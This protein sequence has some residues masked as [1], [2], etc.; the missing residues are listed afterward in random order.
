MPNC[1]L[2]PRILHTNGPPESPPQELLAPFSR[3]LTIKDS[4]RSKF[5]YGESSWTPLYSFW[6]W[7]WLLL[8]TISGTYIVL[9]NFCAIF[10]ST[11]KA[12]NFTEVDI[13]RYILDILFVLFFSPQLNRFYLCPIWSQSFCCGFKFVTNLELK[14]F[15]VSQWQNPFPTCYFSCSSLLLGDW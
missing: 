6:S 2:T 7:N 1:F 9:V 15:R 13:F 8:W 10:T 5:L 3:A 4:G 12:N 14:V 11:A